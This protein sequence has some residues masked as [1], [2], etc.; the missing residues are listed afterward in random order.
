M[1]QSQLEIQSDRRSFL[2]KGALRDLSMSSFVLAVV[3]VGVVL[4]DFSDRPVFWLLIGPAPLGLLHTLRTFLRQR[5]NNREDTS[6]LSLGTHAS[7]GRS[8]GDL[9][10]TNTA[11]D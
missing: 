10:S 6:S 5:L 7:P 8:C 4:A 1:K 9:P 3:L 11:A 2:K